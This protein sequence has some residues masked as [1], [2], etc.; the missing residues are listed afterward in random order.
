MVEVEIRAKAEGVLMEDEK[1]SAH[2]FSIREV[3]I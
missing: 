2:Q 1:N 3:S